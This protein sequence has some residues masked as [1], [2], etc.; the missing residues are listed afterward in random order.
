MWRV[1]LS[2]LHF[3]FQVLHKL[4]PAF[5]RQMSMQSGQLLKFYW[6]FRFQYAKYFSLNQILST[7][8]AT[9]VSRIYQ[10]FPLEI[11]NFTP[12]L[13]I[14]YLFAGFCFAVYACKFEQLKK[15]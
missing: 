4:L 8:R 11:W 5:L 15:V 9:I 6:C 1:I 7:F 2:S 10:L 13:H 3:F 14:I 12:A